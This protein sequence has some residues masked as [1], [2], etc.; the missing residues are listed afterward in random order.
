M[1]RGFRDYEHVVRVAALFVI[2]IVA[3]LVLRWWFLPT[4]FGDYGFY[5][6]GALADNRARPIAY[7]GRA[8]CADCHSDVVEL[9]KGSRHEGIGCESCHG[10]LARHAAGD[11][12]AKPARP[13]PRVTCVRCHAAKAGKPQAYPQVDIADHAPDGECTACHRPH[14]PAIS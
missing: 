4:D 3:F 11:D 14:R 5:R 12:P 2:G 9:R 13:D 7:A 1:G 10:P 8:A 6:T